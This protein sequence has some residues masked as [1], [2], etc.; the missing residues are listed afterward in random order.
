MDG[1]VGETSSSWSSE[2]ATTPASIE[3]NERFIIPARKENIA[4]AKTF[5]STL[6]E[7]GGTNIIA[8]LRQSLQ[9]A[10]WGQKQYK[11][12]A[13]PLIIFLTDGQPNVEM[14]DT[15][16]IVQAVKKLNIDKYDLLCCF[17]VVGR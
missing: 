4:K 8:A 5:A 2:E 12:K 7:T 17:S 10:N 16:E 9:I 14:S 1:T 13:K 15:Q 6:N 11:M 3:I